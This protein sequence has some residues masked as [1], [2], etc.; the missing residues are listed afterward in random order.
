MRGLI[1]LGTDTDVGKTFLASALARA[2]VAQGENVGVYKPVASGIKPAASGIATGQGG[3]P[4][5]LWQ[6]A[7]LTH[8]LPLSRVCPQMFAAP[9]A[10]PV[11]ARLEG[12]QVDEQLL[13]AGAVWWR[14]QCNFLIIEGAGGGLSPLSDNLTNLD[15]AGALQPALGPLP[16]LIIAPHRLGTVNHS[17][18]TIEAMQSR[19]LPLLG[20]FLNVMPSPIAIPSSQTLAP[21]V[22]SHVELLRSF[23]PQCPVFTEL[24]ELVA[25]VLRV[26]L[27]NA[28]NVRYD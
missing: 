6:A 22:S 12:K 28:Y 23:A 2:L 9:L 1:V 27:L 11:A 25:A 13:L 15:L 3:D 19:Q 7:Q 16:C 8:R 21:T 26:N 10:P 18:L 17:L 5:Q 4:E 14:E 20:L 24:P